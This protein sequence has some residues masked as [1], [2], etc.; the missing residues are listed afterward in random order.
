MLIL[1]I[2]ACLLAALPAGLFLANM[3]LYRPPPAVADI[4]NDL[5]KLPI[6][7]LI[8]ARNEEA[9]IERAVKAVLA[10]HQPLEVIVLD[11]HSTDQTVSI[12]KE[13]RQRD[14]RVRL[15]HAPALPTGW[16]GKQ[17]ACATLA[18]LARHEY[19]LFL[20][21]DVRLAAD[22]LPRLVAYQAKGHPDLLSGF[23]QQITGSLAEKLAIPLIHFL[24]LGF[25]P[26]NRMRRYPT[27]T[28]YAAGCGQLFFTTK[29]AYQKMGGHATIKTTL[30]DGIKLPR[31]YRAAGLTTDLCDATGLAQCRMYHRSSEVWSG[32]AKNATEGLANPRLIVPATLLLLGGQVL[33]MVLLIILLAQLPHSDLWALIVT[34]FAT[35][36]A[37]LPRILGVIRFRQSVL[38]AILHPMG[39]LYVVAIQWYAL[40]RKLFGGRASWKG[41]TYP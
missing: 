36:L 38:G 8:P 27:E 15:E 41:R 30:H 13:L 4:A 34:V 16:C 2:V 40:G 12:V 7:V 21:A 39:V 26:M 22:A 35:L 18:T 32:L 17:H 28:A 14:G 29:T 31:A 33:P 19:L 11:D 9:G 6:S 5:R 20:D 3:Q 23:P 1:A 25:L 37:Y 10:N 24:L